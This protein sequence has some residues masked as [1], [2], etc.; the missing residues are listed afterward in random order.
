MTAIQKVY[1]VDLKSTNNRLQVV[2]VIRGFAIISIMLLHNLEHFDVYFLPTNLPDWMVTLDKIIWDSSFFLFAGKSYAMFSLLFG[3]TFFIQL[4]NQAKK[5]K[6]FR[7]I[8]AWRLLLLFVF[9][10]INSTFYQ[11]DILAIYA[12]IGFFIIPFARLSNTLVFCIA[13]ILLI[14]PLELIGLINAIQNPDIKLADPESWAYFGKMD[15]YIKDSSFIDTVIGN[16]TNGKMAVLEWSNENGRYLH[17]LSLFLFG[18]LAGRKNIFSESTENKRFW[19]KTLIISSIVFI[20]LYRIQRYLDTIIASEN[21]RRSVAIMEISWTN[22]SFMLV[23]M[24]GF[25]LL[26][27]TKSF[28]K[29]LHTLSPLG[30]MSLSNYIIQF[31]LGATIYYGFGFGLYK[32]TGA[33]YSLLISITLAILMGYFSTWRMRNHKRGPLETMWHKVT[34]MFKKNQTKNEILETNE[35]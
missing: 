30:R 11:G 7:I 6:D 31:I 1:N 18:M 33:T 21:I 5:G 15:E 34:W 4:N 19:I 25:V 27:Q 32:Y 13:I 26:F 28:H 14:Q 3:L 10:I 9:G 2:D 29:G 35:K 8:F 20:P 22:I 23:L 24:S 16:L 12:V 17:I